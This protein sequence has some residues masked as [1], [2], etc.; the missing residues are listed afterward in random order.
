MFSISV[1]SLSGSFAIIFMNDIPTANYYQ[2][3]WQLIFDSHIQTH[4]VELLCPII[5]KIF[6]NCEI[7][8]YQKQNSAPVLCFYC[9][10]Q[11]SQY[12]VLSDTSRPYTTNCL[13][14]ICQIYQSRSLT[15]SQ[16]RHKSIW[17]RLQP[18]KH[19]LPWSSNAI[20]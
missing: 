6:L 8:R 14:Y 19:N 18:F 10:I 3:A 17:T 1:T 2:N 15:C 7:K 20:A 16:Q 13:T 5:F 11:S 12:V 4:Q 9:D